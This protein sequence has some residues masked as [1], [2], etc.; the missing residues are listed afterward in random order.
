MLRE[1]DKDWRYGLESQHLSGNPK[2]FGKDFDLVR[3]MAFE[4]MFSVGISVEYFRCS[5]NTPDFYKDPNCTWD[6]AIT[7]SAIFDDNP[8]IKIIKQ[9]GWFTE[10][11][12]AKPIL[13][14]L[15]MY[16]D[17]NTKEIYQI[18]D[19]S[20]IRIHY[21]GQQEPSEFRITDKRLD[22]VYGIYWIC[23][24]APER[25]D[26][27]YMVTQDGTHYLKRDD[28]RDYEG[29]EHKH[30]ENPDDRVFQHGDYEK[31]PEKNEKDDS[32]DDYSFL[33]MGR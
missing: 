11:D 28:T 27:F 17:W 10:D 21:F 22:S 25:L 12:E 26:N 4:A 31:Y 20:L 14:Y 18:E 1:V 15:P 5:N 23:K 2:I 7:M 9:L 33:V 29:C 24:L 19:N 3:R 32:E 6:D 30:E 16:K 13:I 8:K